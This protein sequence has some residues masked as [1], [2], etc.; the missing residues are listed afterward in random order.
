[1][2]TIE[3]TLNQYQI[4]LIAL[5]IRRESIAEKIAEKRKRG[6]PEKELLDRY[7]LLGRE[8]TDTWESIH[9]MWEYVNDSDEC[10]EG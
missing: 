6:F 1:M 9:A 2:T 7:Y 10:G 8:I 3:E 5:M 4:T